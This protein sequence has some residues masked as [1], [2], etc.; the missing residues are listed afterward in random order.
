MAQLLYG[1]TWIGEDEPCMGL[2]EINLQ[3]PGSRGFH[4]YQILKVIRNDEVVEYREDMGLA[5]KWKGKD[6][7]RI[8]GGVKENGKFYIE[9][10]VGRLRLMADQLR[11][12][13][14]LDKR[15]LAQV[16]RIRE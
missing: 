10:T 14:G 4:R 16:D 8:L 2:F 13:S 7:L 6:Q 11:G 1:T 15:E 12:N 5:K 9:E 3:S